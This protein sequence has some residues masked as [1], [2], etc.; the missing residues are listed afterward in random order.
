MINGYRL[1]VNTIMLMN[2]K[3]DEGDMLA[4]SKI[5][6]QPDDNLESLHDKLSLDGARLLIPT[7][8]GFAEGR[9]TPI[10][11]DHSKASYT[12]KIGPQTAWLDFSRSDAALLNLIRAMSPFPGAWFNDGEERI[13]VFKA[14]AGPKNVGEPGTVKIEDNKILVGCGN[15]SS[16]YLNELQRPG[17]SRLGAAE[18]LRGYQFKNNRVV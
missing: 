10:T 14:S 13:K 3:M 8:T 12:G 6:I 7:L 4:V 2:S 9:I 17:K 15:D 5:E 18:F 11:Q 1:T 16:I